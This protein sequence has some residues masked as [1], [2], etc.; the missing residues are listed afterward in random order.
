[1]NP[2][3]LSLNAFTLQIGGSAGWIDITDPECKLLKAFAMTP[4]RRLKTSSILELVGK[5][6]G[7][8]GK[9]A[10]EVQIVR[11]RKKLLQAGATDPTIKSIRGMGYQLCVPLQLHTTTTPTP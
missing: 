2:V 4:T 8:P 1:M 5:E 3:T 6:A 10:L 9:R 11:L 7:E